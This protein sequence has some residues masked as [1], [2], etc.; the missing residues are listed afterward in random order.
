MRIA[1]LS[2]LVF[3]LPVSQALAG[4]ITYTNSAAFETALAGAP[5]LVENFTGFTNQETIAP[6][7]TFNGITYASFDITA[8]TEG[9]ISNQ[10]QLQRSEPRRR[11]G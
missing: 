8:G 9:I 3:L 11:P 1:K 10:L 7:S 5:T 2:I 4:T 6:G